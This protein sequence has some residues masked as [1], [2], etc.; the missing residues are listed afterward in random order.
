MSGKYPRYPAYKDSGV[1]WL[2]E[3]P[4]HWDVFTIKNIFHLVTQQCTERPKHCVGL[5]N[6]EGWSGKLV[7]TD[8]EFSGA[9]IAFAQGD[10]LF[11]KLRPYLAK[12]YLTPQPGCAVGDF[13]VLR[14]HNDHVLYWY[15]WYQF[16][17]REFI[18]IA[19]SST[20][21]AKM[22]RVS[23]EFLSSMIFLLP[24]LPEQ[25]TIA[26]F[27]D[28]QT[29]RI[30][31][32]IA[33]YEKLIALLKEKRQALISHAVTKGLNPAVPMKDS[34]VEWLGEMPEHWGTVSLRWRARCQS[35]SAISA[36][37]V[38]PT[39]DEKRAI[40]VIGGNGIMG[41][42]AE[43]NVEADILAV[44]RVGALCGNVHVLTNPSWITDNALILQMDK[45]YINLWFLFRV[46]AAR[47]L[48]EIA[49]STAQPLITGSQLLD[50]R[51]PLPPLPEQQ[52]IAA[53]LDNE[54]SKMDALIQQAE[55]GIDLLKERRT[56]LIS[57]AVTGKIDVRE[58]TAA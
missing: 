2:G 17:N 37:E 52:A 41:Y 35:G 39:Q 23:W 55:T 34:G 50:Q 29:T 40:P 43:H 10:I 32:L 20:Y 7:E 1:E 21:G 25:Q 12:V 22:P 9:G 28:I 33:E 58:I 4:G 31:A 11:G 15:A 56:T 13:H 18:A 14:C 16:I 49:S 38:E 3:V 51:V 30:D 36:E 24:P 26:T 6:I 27:L 54:T 44:G 45:Q 5:E 53:Y 19:D 42:T 57:D 46:L 47:N 48:N 8:N